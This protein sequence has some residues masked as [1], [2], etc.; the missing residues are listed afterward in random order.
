M[1]RPVENDADADQRVNARRK[2]RARSGPRAYL[3][4]NGITKALA[5][6]A[7]SAYSAASMSGHYSRTSSLRQ[8]YDS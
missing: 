7:N 5:Q 1:F 3:I 6:K 2:F 8:T 4:V